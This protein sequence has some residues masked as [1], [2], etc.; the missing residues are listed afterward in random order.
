MRREE[1]RKKKQ[2]SKMLEER[3]EGSGSD[4]VRAISLRVAA[5]REKGDDRDDE[6]RNVYFAKS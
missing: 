4:E 3:K 5:T 2:G 6:E 1:A